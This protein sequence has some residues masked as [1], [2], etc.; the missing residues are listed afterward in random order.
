MKPKELKTYA[1]LVLS[2]DDNVPD[3][4]MN[5]AQVNHLR[6]L[7][8]WMRCEWMLDDDM[9]RGFISGAQGC[10]EMGAATPEEAGALLAERAE[11]I[12]QCPAYVRQAVKMLTKALRDHER[13][14]G[15]LEPHGGGEVEP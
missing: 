9:Q 5:D 15:I 3:M 2:G 12:K 10:V 6:R 7:L 14:A 11:K 1:K 13:A 8:A 4:P